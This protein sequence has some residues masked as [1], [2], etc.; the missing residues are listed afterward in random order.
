M[1]R[2]R[3]PAVSVRNHFGTHGKALQAGSLLVAMMR[4]YAKGLSRDRL[5]VLLTVSQTKVIV[6]AESAVPCPSYVVDSFLAFAVQ[7]IVAP[8]ELELEFRLALAQSA[9]QVSTQFSMAYP[10]SEKQNGLALDGIIPANNNNNNNNNSMLHRQHS[11]VDEKAEGPVAPP[12]MTDNII[13]KDGFELHPQP[14][15][16]PLD[17]LNW[18]RFQKHSVLAIVMLMVCI[19]RQFRG[20]PY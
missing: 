18:S 17:P 10:T 16:D 15:S 1:T 13:T 20:H 12:P 5:V 6:G 7:R 4:L 14:T 2:W 11:P 19:S 9:L 3:Q 8:A